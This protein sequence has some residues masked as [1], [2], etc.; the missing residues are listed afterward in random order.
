M[1]MSLSKLWEMVKDREACNAAVY[2]VAESDM[3][4]QLNNNYFISINLEKMKVISA[5]LERWVEMGT[6]LHDSG[7]GKEVLT[8][9]GSWMQLL[10]DQHVHSWVSA[11]EKPSPLCTGDL[12]GMCTTGPEAE[13]SGKRVVWGS[14]CSIRCSWTGSE[15]TMLPREVQTHFRTVVTGGRED[16]M[17]SS[18]ELLLCPQHLFP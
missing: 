14:M 12:D 18:L 13:I 1:D 4:Q 5:K 7:E 15:S 8:L 3:T 16:Y 10:L 11:P 2:G 17:R 9:W 6:L